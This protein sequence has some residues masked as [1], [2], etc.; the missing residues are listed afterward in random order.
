M[1]ADADPVIHLGRVFFS[2]IV[3]QVSD[4]AVHQDTRLPLVLA[5]AG[6]HTHVAAGALPTAE[7]PP[8]NLHTQCYYCQILNSEHGNGKDRNNENDNVQKQCW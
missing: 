3:A 8:G 7:S 6:A 4:L 5:V 2:L 1:Q